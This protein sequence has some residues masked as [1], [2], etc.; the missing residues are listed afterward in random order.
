MLETS[1]HFD[2][3]EFEAS[4]IELLKDLEINQDKFVKKMVM[5]NLK[6][7][8]KESN[9]ALF[10]IEKRILQNVIIVLERAASFGN[11]MGMNEFGEPISVIPIPPKEANVDFINEIL[12]RSFEMVA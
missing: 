10:S 12:D 4:L 2:Q 8:Q 3:D 6:K 11:T 9:E 1:N 5:K 7:N